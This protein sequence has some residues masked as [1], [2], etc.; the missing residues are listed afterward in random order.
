MPCAWCGSYSKLGTV[1]E[2]CGSPMPAI[3]PFPLPDDL[4]ELTGKRRLSL[5][6]DDEEAQAAQDL[7]QRQEAAS[8]PTAVAVPPVA[9]APPPRRAP[10]AATPEDGGLGDRI[11][12]ALSGAVYDEDMLGVVGEAA[13]VDLLVPL[14]TVSSPPASVEPAPAT[15][16]EAPPD[17]RGRTGGAED[18]GDRG[19]R[20]R[21]R[22]SR[23]PRPSRTTPRRR[24]WPTRVAT[25]SSESEPEHASALLEEPPVA[26]EVSAQ[27]E[28][29]SSD[30]PAVEAGAADA[31]DEQESGPRGLWRKSRR[32]SDDQKGDEVSAA[33]NLLFADLSDLFRRKPA[34]ADAP[35][36][37]QAEPA[38]QEIDAEA[39]PVVVEAV[40]EP[41]DDSPDV[42]RRGG[43][44]R[45]R[46]R[47][48]SH[49]DRG[50]RLARR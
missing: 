28:G 42:D 36:E 21:P 35:S 3:Y 43:I 13:P 37:D 22:P 20:P 8:A 15:Q 6:H 47:H 1:C 33:S 48:R 46:D 23:L 10:E 19:R 12:G 7:L 2:V 41:A 17:G 24:S 9:P 26:D 25:A 29:P 30:E 38:A 5:P 39:E 34:Q 45:G 49:R 16:V 18:R 40:A 27:P 50:V 32:R 31:D 44:G 4:P 11:L 14:E